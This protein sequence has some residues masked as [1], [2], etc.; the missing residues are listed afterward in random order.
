MAQQKVNWPLAYIIT[1]IIDALQFGGDFIPG[2]DFIVIP[3]NEFIDIA[4]GAAIGWWGKRIGALDVGS[5]IAIGF[6]FLIEEGTGGS[7]P[8]WVGDIGILHMKYTANEAMNANAMIGAA[9]NEGGPANVGGRRGPTRRASPLN[10]GD[11]RGP[12]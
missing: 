8:F 7:A 11:S 3:A 5:G 1:G 4:I 6:T 10:R 12:R 2:V 9:I